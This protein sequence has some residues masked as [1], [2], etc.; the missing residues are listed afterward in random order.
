MLSAVMLSAVMLSAVM[1]TVAIQSFTMHNCAECKYA[2]LTIVILI[3]LKISCFVEL[4]MFL[5]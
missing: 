2:E 1:L 5:V 4:S 3:T